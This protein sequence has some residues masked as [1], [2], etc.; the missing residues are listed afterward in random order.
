[1][2][3]FSFLP[4][5]I[6]RALI[7]RLR[8]A[9]FVIRV[10]RGD[11]THIIEAPAEGPDPK[12]LRPPDIEKN[13]LISPPGSPPEGWEPIKEDPP[14]S[15]PLADDLIAALRKLQLAERAQ[16]GSN[17]EVLVH[18]EDGAGI[19]VYVEDC[20]GEALAGPEGEEDWEY[21]DDNPSRMRWKPTPT[22]MP[23]VPWV[24]A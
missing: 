22:S 14:N 2:S 15:V 21:G 1:M 12:Y 19:G 9:E 3:A 18:P 23:P 17:I 5:N 24:V 16:H 8:R 6:F 7:R 4:T 11:R 13:F 10:Y 20:D